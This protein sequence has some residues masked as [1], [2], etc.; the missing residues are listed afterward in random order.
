MRKFGVAAIVLIAIV[1]I[2]LI[3]QSQLRDTPTAKADSAHTGTPASAADTTVPMTEVPVRGAS[4]EPAQQPGSPASTNDRPVVSGHIQPLEQSPAPVPSGDGAVVLK[5]AS[6]AYSNV[7]SMRADFVQRRENP[8]LGSTLTSR[9]I[10]Y[11]RA[12]DRF[13]LKFTQPA[14][15][16]I[17]A[18]GRYFWVYYPSVDRK[19]VIRAPASEEGAGAIDLKAQFI[20]DPVQRFSHTYHGTEKLNGRTVHV[21]TLTPRR[22][23]G[24][25]TLK[26]WVDALDSLVRRFLIVEPTGAKVEFQLSNLTINPTLGNEIFRFTLPPDAVVI[27]R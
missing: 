2:A 25:K 11:Q 20:G 23:S 4:P 22:E 18:D 9:G 14:G 24:Y 8:L 27:E 7:R 15:D 10:L 12:P 5:R 19:Q 3:A 17:V 1:A 21:L 16:I 6:A 26:V 13:A